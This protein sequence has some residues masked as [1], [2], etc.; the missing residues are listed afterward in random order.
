MSPPKIP[1]PLAQDEKAP[2]L[3]PK[4]S[5]SQYLVREES[6]H[7]LVTKLSAASL[8]DYAPT[9]GLGIDVSAYQNSQSGHDVSRT[10]S[11][12]RQSTS[13]SPKT[14]ELETMDYEKYYENL[15]KPKIKLGPR[16]ITVSEKS[17]RS[18]YE[19]TRPVSSLPPGLQPRSKP[20][21]PS[22]APPTQTKLSAMP[23]GSSSPQISMSTLGFSH[24]PPPIPDDSAFYPPRPSSRGSSRSLPLSTRTATS[25]KTSKTAVTPEKLRLMKAM[26]LRK[27]QM[28]KSTP[29]ETSTFASTDAHGAVAQKTEGTEKKRLGDNP[30]PLSSAATN[31]ADS[32]IS[33]DYEASGGSDLDSDANSA[34]SRPQ[35]GATQRGPTY[36]DYTNLILDPLSP[37]PKLNNQESNDC[38]ALGRVPEKVIHPHPQSTILRVNDS[39]GSSIQ[40]TPEMLQTEGFSNSLTIPN[41]QKTPEIMIAESEQ[42]DPEVQ[43]K[44]RGLVEPLT[45]DIMPSPPIPTPNTEQN[46]LS[47]EEFY[48]ELQSATF[49][50]AKPVIISRSP[51][52]PFFPRRPSARSAQSAQSIMTIASVASLTSIAISKA[53]TNP[54]ERAS[55]PSKHLS[56]D[57]PIEL[58]SRAQSISS[59]RTPDSERGDPMSAATQRKVSSGISK[60]IAA[61]AEKSTREGSPP[62][63]ATSQSL[64]E[65]TSF[66][67]MRKASIRDTSDSRPSSTGAESRPTSKLSMWPGPEPVPSRRESAGH[68]DT[69]SVTARIVRPSPD[70]NGSSTTPGELHQSPILINHTRSA[71]KPDYP[72]MDAVITDSV[73]PVT[74]NGSIASS[75]PVTR[76]QSASYSVRSDESIATS[77]R[78]SFSRYRGH[79]SP[80]KSK[81]ASTASLASDSRESRDDSE[82]SSSRTTRFFKRIST[83]GNKRKSVTQAP[84]SPPVTP[85]VTSPK[86]DPTPTVAPA[87]LSPLASSRSVPSLIQAMKSSKEEPV[88]AT[89][90]V[91]PPVVIGDIN[92]QFPDNLVS[93]AVPGILLFKQDIY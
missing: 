52:S 30:E 54:V 16:P 46:Y 77:A 36:R 88:T 49:Q 22:H 37:I 43:K 82:K 42:K 56:P 15:Y 84:T 59:A 21:N 35:S 14:T 10:T 44:R 6:G 2:I 33:M 92:V 23:I 18:S 73:A 72:P 76:P 11:P 9:E 91:P 17:K 3:E 29:P 32:G 83:L 26:E 74:S 27:K 12:V 24:S 69:I 20:A 66:V 7:R 90:D 4:P 19:N 70:Q 39:A 25:T 78:K 1:S 75:G 62:G 61:L 13:S 58:Q 87:T 89:E 40:A 68:K 86:A 50:E 53:P 65:K 34:R 57:A 48:E 55:S 64:S 63:T 5:L 45:I 79:E 47:D 85:P 93:G 38:P 71:P 41:G 80:R 81:G 31:K 8:A 51:A 28:R 67:N 60:R